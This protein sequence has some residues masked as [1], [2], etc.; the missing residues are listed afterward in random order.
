MQF[1]V[2]IPAKNEEQ[3]LGRCLDSIA[4]NGW[5]PSLYEVI[6]V[7][8]GSSDGTAAIARERGGRVYVLPGVTIS[9]LRN[10]G[11]FHSSGRIIA[12][13]DA[14]CAVAP[15]WFQAASR[16][17]EEDGVA[18]FG[19]P[20]TV[21]EGGTWVQK[22]W[23]NVRGKPGEVADVE[24]LESANLL[25]NR[26]AF[27]A[28]GGFDDSL[29]TC[30]DYD[31]TQRLKQHG[32]LISD[33][34]VAAIHYREPATVAQFMKKEMW[35]GIGNVNALKRILRDGVDRRELPSLLLPL[36]HCL[37]LLALPLS[38]ALSL[39]AGRVALLLGV[40]AFSAWQGALLL[41]CLLKYRRALPAVP[42]IFIL[43][44]VYFLARGAALLR[45]P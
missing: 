29:K 20:A 45:Q 15:G 8:N 11:A 24:W 14:D 22:A 37:L 21:P 35:R 34:R 12:F 36:F 1:S 3:N 38:F 7:D 43:L 28:A 16:Y 27:L 40:A 5:D 17:L 30:E 19:S 42:Q 31:L 13:L 39:Y 10:Y 25:V 18:A 6:V 33:H 32:K 2:V 23:F 44:N 41:L 4:A 9:A 26:G